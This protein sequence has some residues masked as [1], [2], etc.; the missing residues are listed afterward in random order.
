M[1]DQNK[2][3]TLSS[4]LGFILLSAGC[5]IGLG[6]VWRFPYI[7]GEYGGAIFVLIYLVFLCIIGFPVMVMEFSIGRASR[8]NISGA[9]TELEPKGTKWHLY[10][11]VAIAGNYLL[12]M[13]YTTI[14]GWLLYYVFATLTGAYQSMDTAGVAAFFSELQSQPGTMFFWMAV[15]T[16]AGFLIC[17]L[18]LQKGVEK[19]TKGMMA[20]LIVLIVVLAVHSIII[21]KSYDGIRFYLMPS[22][23][24]LSKHPLGEVIFAAMSQA[25]FTLSIGMGGMTIFGSYIDKQQSLSGESIYVITL[26]TF[27]AFM[28]GLIIFPACF[29][30][31]VKPDA[32]PG[33]LFVTLPNIFTQMAG[34]RFWGFL[35]FVFMSF[36][37]LTTLVAVFENIISYWIDNHGWS[38]KK[39]CIVNCLLLIALAL[40]CILGFNLMSGFQPLGEGSAVLDL[41][42]FLISSTIMPLGS[43]LIV[44]FCTRK[45]GWGFDAFLKEADEGKGIKFPAFLAFYCKWVLPLIILVIFFKG[46]YDIFMK[47]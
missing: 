37:A 3:E 30:Y 22:L 25:F 12:M 29:A 15:G 44:I 24:N 20:L 41:E 31:G 14:T 39:A 35:F 7:V 38:R 36:A 5:A 40:P 21:D 23:E 28:S 33:L 9:L 6:N 2:R 43:L 16:I 8:K 46:Y 11:P 10:G 42:D 19:I 32:G 34:G 13:F 18:G 26:D 27:V 4:R 47:I 17:A 45:K 1:A